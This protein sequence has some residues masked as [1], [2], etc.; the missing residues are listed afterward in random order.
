[1]LEILKQNI[2]DFAKVIDPREEHRNY[3]AA[4]TA[5][6]YGTLVGSVQSL[7]DNYFYRFENKVPAVLYRDTLDTNDGVEGLV[8][9]KEGNRVDTDLFRKYEIVGKAGE[10]HN[11]VTELL[12]KINIDY[13]ILQIVMEEYLI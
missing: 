6:I 3:I 10:I 9:N 12:L 8:L 7:I 13:P 11:G 5:R 1:M 2:P 4:N